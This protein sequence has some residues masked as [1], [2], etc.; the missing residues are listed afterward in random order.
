MENNDDDTNVQNIQMQHQRL[1]ENI[2]FGGDDH[3]TAS[4]PG[5]HEDLDGVMNN[6]DGNNDEEIRL[7]FEL[8]IL[9]NM[10]SSF[11]STLQILEEARDD[12]NHNIPNDVD[13]LRRAS[14]RIRAA[15][16]MLREQIQ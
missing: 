11:V 9:R 7:D 16:A 8:Q 5:K 1:N 14:E 4:T 12:L 10:R 3:A 15:F 2:E 6:S 13:E